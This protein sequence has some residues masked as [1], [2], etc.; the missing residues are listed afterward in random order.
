MEVALGAAFFAGCAERG[1]RAIALTLGECPRSVKRAAPSR[2][3]ACSVPGARPVQT[4]GARFPLSQP[5]V[6]TAPFPIG[7]V[8]GVASRAWELCLKRDPLGLIV[9]PFVIFF[10]VYVFLSL[11]TEVLPDIDRL[12]E[13]GPLLGAIL[14]VMPLVVFARVFG[15]AWIQVRTDAGAHGQ[16]PAWGDTFTRALAR[17]WYLVIVM[18]VVYALVQVGIFLFVIPGLILYVLCSFANQ[19]AV[20]GPGRLVASLRMSRDL[21]EHHA[22]AWFGMVAY[23]VIVFLGLGILIGILRQ[24]IAPSLPAGDAGFIAN[25]LLGLPLQVCLLVFTCCWTLFYRELEARRAI[26]LAA[27]PPAPPLTPVSSRPTASAVSGRE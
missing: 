26:H 5:P 2:M 8:Q 1:G 11:L 21:V 25:L 6:A 19:A 15:E 12:A 9:V 24:S 17:A 13:E 14:G 22:P 27:H 3:G 23:W 10:P 7:S 16:V 20:L 4:R 18:L